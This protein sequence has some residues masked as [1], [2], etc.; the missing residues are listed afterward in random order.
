MPLHYQWGK[1][2]AGGVPRNPPSIVTTPPLAKA[3]SL[4]PCRLCAR[5]FNMSSQSL[6]CS[7]LSGRIRAHRCATRQGGEVRRDCTVTRRQTAGA[8]S[9]PR[10]T[11]TAKLLAESRGQPVA[12]S[13]RL[14][15]CS[16]AVFWKRTGKAC[17]AAPADWLKRKMQQSGENGT[18]GDW[19]ATGTASTAACRRSHPP[20]KSGP[21]NQTPRLCPVEPCS[22]IYL[23][24][25]SH[26]GYSRPLHSTTRHRC[27][28][29]QPACLLRNARR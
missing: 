14:A 28:C 20:R 17:T 4:E 19:H 1:P 10:V 15:E 21:L 23:D 13:P 11:V 27:A 5:A 29:T 18:V 3:S 7:L 16:S 26:L 2:A 6:S 22:S 8:A 24:P 25:S 9:S 12:I